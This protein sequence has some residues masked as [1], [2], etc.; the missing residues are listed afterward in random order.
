MTVR[1]LLADDQP[2]VRAALQMVIAD[3][4]G[5]DLAGEAGTGAEAVRMTEDLR[6]DV[7]VMDIRMPGMDG[8]EATRLITEGSGARVL[9]LTTFDDDEYVYGALRAGASG[10]LVK[11]MA[12]DDIL[13]AVRVVAAGDALIAPRV[14]RRLIER[15]AGRIAPGPRPRRVAGLTEREAEVLTLVGRGMSNAEI[16]AELFISTA[17]VKTY[18]TRLLAKLDARD[19]VRL[20]I[21]AYEACLVSPT[22]Q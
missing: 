14:T 17:T 18:V 1:V 13:A 4:P 16:A 20:V 12:L 10:F 22:P 21:I 5:L 6:P 19:R 2:L 7:V 8:I 15:F 3:A 11:D 9:V